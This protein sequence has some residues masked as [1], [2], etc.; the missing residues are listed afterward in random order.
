MP[1][2]IV[3]GRDESVKQ[4]RATRAEEHGRYMEAEVCDVL[5][6]ATWRPHIG[7]ALMA[8]AQ[9]VGGVDELAI[10]ERGDFF[11]TTPPRARA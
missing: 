5:A 6:R 7:L 4:Q 3:R 9:D 11:P 10:P 8:A 1:S 2:N